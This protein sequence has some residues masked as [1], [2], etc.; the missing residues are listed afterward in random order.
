MKTYITPLREHV[1]YA[2]VDPR[3]GTVH[4]IGR[5]HNPRRRL[6]RHM[7]GADGAERGEWIR[8]LRRHKLCADMMLLERVPLDVGQLDAIAASASAEDVRRYPGTA[9]EYALD[10]LVGER[11][12]FW[13]RFAERGGNIIF[14]FRRAG[15][16]A[17]LVPYHWQG[18]SLTSRA[19]R[20]ARHAREAGQNRA[21]YARW[22]EAHGLPSL[23]E[24]ARAQGDSSQWSTAPCPLCD[25][26]GD[27]GKYTPDS[28]CA[29]CGGSGKVGQ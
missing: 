15:A 28:L 21:E 5:T 27:G 14:D 1:I 12:D 26:T 24:L 4:H 16:L 6:A 25:G 20:G 13:Q 7:D 17:E 29:R 3:D 9:R 8:E 11:E 10:V 18:H 19:T 2:L 22:R 23:A